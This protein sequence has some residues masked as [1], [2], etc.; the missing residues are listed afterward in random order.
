MQVD[1]V[2]RAL[3]DHSGMSGNAVSAALNRSRE[4]ARI[5]SQPGRVPR[6]DTVADVAD[7]AGCEVVIID[8]TTGETVATIDPPRRA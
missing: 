8:R 3:I 4:W 6:I 7:V 1:R 2:I 5:T